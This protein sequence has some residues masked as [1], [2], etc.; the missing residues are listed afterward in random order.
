MILLNSHIISEL[1]RTVPDPLVKIS[2]ANHP[3]ASLFISSVTEAEL[4]YGALLCPDG[5]KRTELLVAIDGLLTEDFA[6]RI[7]PFDSAAAV[8]FASIFADRPSLVRP[9]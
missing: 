2:F 1:M 4:R 9:I 3:P 8:A 7:L 6:G 5:R